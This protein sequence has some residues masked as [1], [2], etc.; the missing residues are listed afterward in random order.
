MNMKQLLLVGAS[1]FASTGWG[2]G[3][4]QEM[5]HQYIQIAE[6]EIDPG[7]LDAY[8]AAVR[9]HIGT[10]IRVEPGVLALYAVAV[11]DNPTHIRV[12]EIY[13]NT[14]AYRAHLEAPHFK[15]FKAVTEKMVRSLKLVQ[16]V[17]VVLGTKPK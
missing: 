12:F 10:A 4:A 1:L 2:V 15:K 17:P 8:T 11:K 3:V 7:Q 14:D 16:T 6:I 9:E 13:A 5:H